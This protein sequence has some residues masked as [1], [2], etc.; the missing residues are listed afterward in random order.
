MLKTIL[1]VLSLAD[2]CHLKNQTCSMVM[3]IVPICYN[4]NTKCTTDCFFSPSFDIA[5]GLKMEIRNKLV[6]DQSSKR[7]VQGELCIHHCLKV[8]MLFPQEQGHSQ[9]CR[10]QAQLC[11]ARALY[12]QNTHIQGHYHTQNAGSNPPKLNPTTFYI[13]LV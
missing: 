13:W 7:L 1:P 8:T 6:S 12:I 4:H 2:N 5:F 9:K 10:G 11:L 3:L